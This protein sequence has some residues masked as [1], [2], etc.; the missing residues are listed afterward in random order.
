VGVGDWEKHELFPAATQEP[1]Q[2]R[3]HRVQNDGLTGNE[4]E[5]DAG[6]DI[7]MLRFEVVQPLA[8]QIK[9]EEK[10]ANDKNRIDRKFD[11]KRS[12]TLGSFLFHETE[13]L[14]E[15][16]DNVPSASTFQRFKEL[17]CEW[18][19]T[20]ALRLVRSQINCAGSVFS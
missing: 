10:I 7:A 20:V 1:K 8:K 15:A 11:R 5:G 14:K 13:S 19:V 3:R 2:K 4:Q 16:S 6:I 18:D 17:T 9:D 12:Q